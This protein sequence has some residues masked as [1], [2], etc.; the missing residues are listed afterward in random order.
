[1]QPQKRGKPDE[2]NGCAALACPLLVVAA[3]GLSAAPLSPSA[4]TLAQ[5]VG[6]DGVINVRW[7]GHRH[8]S[9]R[10][11]HCAIGIMAMDGDPRSAAWRL[12]PLLANPLPA[13]TRPRRATLSATV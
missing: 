8:H 11:G 1:M 13:P 3:Q 5:A 7:R 2:Q 6:A 10:G 4:A 12:E 9:W